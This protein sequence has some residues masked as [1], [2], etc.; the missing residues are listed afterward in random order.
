M[1]VVRSWKIC[2]SLHRSNK[3]DENV[4]KPTPFSIE[5]ILPIRMTIAEQNQ[6]KKMKQETCA[7]FSK[8]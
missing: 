2:E 7:G 6:V 3:A 4:E 1:D 5:N 8:S